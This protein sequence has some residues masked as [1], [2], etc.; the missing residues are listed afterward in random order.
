MIPS[1]FSSLPIKLPGLRTRERE[2]EDGREDEREDGREDEREDGRDGDREHG[3]GN[4]LSFSHLLIPSTQVEM[5]Y[6]ILKHDPGSVAGG[7]G[8]IKRG[9]KRWKEDEK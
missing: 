8:K 3:G 4:S 5:V 7:S 2:R 6:L 9:K 1:I